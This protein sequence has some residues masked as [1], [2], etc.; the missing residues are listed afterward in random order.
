MPDWSYRTV[1]RPLLFRLPPAV[2]RDFALG[3][4]GALARLP[5]GPAVIDFMGHMRP[6]RRLGWTVGGT[7]FPTRVGLGACVDPRLQASRAFAQFGIAFWELGPVTINDVRGGLIQRD[8][9]R[10]TLVFHSPQD[11]PALSKVVQLLDRSGLPR[12]FVR[13][14][15]SCPADGRGP[16]VNQIIEQLA[17]RSAGFILQVTDPAESHQELEQVAQYIRSQG[18]SLILVAVT[19]AAPGEAISAIKSLVR[20]GLIDGV[21]V[22][23]GWWDAD[24]SYYIGKAASYETVDSVRSW[25]AELPASAPIIADGGIHEPQQAL[26]LLEAGCDLVSVSS[27]LIFTGPGLIKRI[28]EG[29]L[30]RLPVSSE[31]RLAPEELS[32]F[33]TC[34]MALGM[35]VGGVMAMVIAT[36]RVVMPYDEAMAGLTRNEICG[37]NP[38]LLNFMAHD[39]VTLAGTMLAVGILYLA[40]SVYGSRH[41]MHWARR[42]VIVS[43]STGFVSFFLFLGFGYFDPFHAFVTAILFQLLMMAVHCGLP[44]YSNPIAPELTNDR[45]WLLSQ[46]GQLLFVIHGV[47]LIVAGCVIAIVGISTVFV[48]EDLDFMRTTADQLFGAHPRLVPLIAHDRATFGGMLIACGV[49]VLLSALWGFRRGQAWLWWALMSAGTAA[50]GATIYIHWHVGYLSLEHLLP[51]YAGLGL[52]LISGALSRSHLCGAATVTTDNR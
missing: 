10:E 22:D 24:G 41:G 26:E 50:Y 45:A 38:H 12:P 35:L 33:W 47:V 52:L 4:M 37:I 2:A 25:R 51:A 48:Q 13:L 18:P 42:T 8:G 11:S 39:R 43:A 32:W 14:P 16:E 7:T 5:W 15:L 23:G 20:T 1:F 21:Y 31:K 36:T 46:W 6:D 19:S 30:Y 9:A 27:G 49:C 3:C 29:L 40:L 28:N 17:P 34:L 44:G